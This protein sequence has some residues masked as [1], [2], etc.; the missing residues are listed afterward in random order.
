MYLSSNTFYSFCS[1]LSSRQHQVN[2][3][4][5]EEE[6]MFVLFS[7]VYLFILSVSVFR[8]VFV[9]QKRFWYI[10]NSFWIQLLASFLMTQY[11]WHFTALLSTAFILFLLFYLSSR[12]YYWDCT[13][14][15]NNGLFSP[16]PIYLFL[17]VIRDLSLPE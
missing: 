16:P 3:T 10:T 9:N 4:C 8:N 2:N 14:C 5:F 6:R 13:A 1:K 15:I 7:F 11:S 17:A 12:E